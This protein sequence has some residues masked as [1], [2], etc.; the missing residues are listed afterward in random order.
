MHVD[1]S[2]FKV[3]LQSPNT[4]INAAAIQ[5]QDR[6]GKV[7]T[8]EG[9]HL[10]V[11]YVIVTVHCLCIPAMYG[12]NLAVRRLPHDAETLPPYLDESA[13]VPE[14]EADGE[15]RP[16]ATNPHVQSGGSPLASNGVM[17]AA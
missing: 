9:P 6:S 7:L 8:P 10:C 14:Q 13:L 5:S 17:I 1:N 4:V 15:R 3:L 2:S 16:A 12:G 11:G